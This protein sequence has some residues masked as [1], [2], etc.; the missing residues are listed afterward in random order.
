MKIFDDI[1]HWNGYGGKFNLAAGRCRLRLFDL[2]KD[3]SQ[4]V[5]QLKPIIAVVSDLPGDCLSAPKKVSLRACISHVATTIV[6]RF[7][8][9]HQRM[10]LIEYYP[11]KTYGK[12]AEKFIPEKYDQVDL[13]WHGDK[14]LFPNWRPLQAPLLDTV[15][16]LVANHP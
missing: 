4:T 7:K 3:E 6:H 12:D 1:F 2:S 14:A 13:Q 5:A 15:R 9:D 10:V 8:V 16:T 11:R